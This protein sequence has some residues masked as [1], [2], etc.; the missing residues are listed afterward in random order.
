MHP[1]PP[2]ARIASARAVAANL[3]DAAAMCLNDQ[4]VIRARFLQAAQTID[5]VVMM[6]EAQTFVARLNHDTIVE[7][8]R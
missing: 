8:T 5:E 7:M 2:D 3:R 1:S 6:V 4:D